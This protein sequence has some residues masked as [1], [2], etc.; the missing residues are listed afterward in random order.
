M[1]TYRAFYNKDSFYLE[2]KDITLESIKDS[3]VAVWDVVAENMEEAYMKMQGENWSPNGEARP[4]IEGLGLKHTSMS[5]S[6]I[7]YD[8]D[9]KKYYQVANIGFKEVV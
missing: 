3:H 2:D 9:E 5:C 7:L 6:D 1:K 4:V 8:M